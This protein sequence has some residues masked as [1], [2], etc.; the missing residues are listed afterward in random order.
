MKYLVNVIFV[1][2]VLF[3]FVPVVFGQETGDMP[4][5]YE[6]LF[7]EATLAAVLVVVAAVKL[8]R[9][10]I[11][12]KGGWAVVLTF[13]VSI[14]YGVIQY[15]I[16]HPQGI[17]YGVFIG[18]LAAGSFYLTKNVGKAALPEASKGFSW[19]SLFGKSFF[20]GLFQLAKFVILRKI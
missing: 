11:N 17:L 1:L 5:I 4:A 16:G 18:L 14:V 3:S 13:L 9:N 19:K 7:N 10:L 6:S 8:L 15:G 12:V 2:L 20:T